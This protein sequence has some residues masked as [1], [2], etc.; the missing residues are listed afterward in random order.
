MSDLQ[1]AHDEFI[2]QSLWHGPLDRSA[3]LLSQRPEIGTHSI[4]A[5]SILGDGAAVRAFLA[6]D[7]ATAT[8]KGGPRGWDPLTYLCFSKYLRLE[9]ARTAGFVDAAT[10]LLDAGADPNT[11]FYAGDKK[12]ENEWECA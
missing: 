2:D 3:E 9:P 12:V 8:A 11:G 6:R 4:H 10:A 7:G 5:A 1:N